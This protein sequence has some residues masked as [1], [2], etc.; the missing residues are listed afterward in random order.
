MEKGGR[1]YSIYV[2]DRVHERML[3]LN[4]FEKRRKVENS[5]EKLKL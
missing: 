1:P 4:L 2:S 5:K 3:K